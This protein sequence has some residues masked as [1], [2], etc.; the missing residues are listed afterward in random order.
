MVYTAESTPLPHNTIRE[1]LIDRHGN[2]WVGTM[3]GVAVFHPG[4]DFPL[5]DT[6]STLYPWREPIRKD[7]GSGD[8]GDLTY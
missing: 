1:L 7:I 3:D 4:E 6:A 8:Q 5:L 2:L